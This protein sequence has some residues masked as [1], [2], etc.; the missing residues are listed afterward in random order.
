[1]T[2]SQLRCALS[3]CTSALEE[4]H[5]ESLEVYGRIRDLTPQQRH[6]AAERIPA[7]LMAINM[8]VS[9][10]VEH[11]VE[12]SRALLGDVTVQVP[13]R[14]HR[15]LGPDLL[16]D[17]PPD[18]QLEVV[19]LLRHASAVQHQDDAIDGPTRIEALQQLRRHRVISLLGDGAAR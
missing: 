17:P 16:P 7:A 10:Q 15:H 9:A 3:L 5:R 18:V 13:S 19:D 6:E 2:A 12:G 11:H 4:E 8:W 14:H 1:M